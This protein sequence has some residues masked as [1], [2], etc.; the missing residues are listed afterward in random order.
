M[1]FVA[2][3]AKVIRTDLAFEH[4][5]DR[6]EEVGQGANHGQRGSV[7]RTEEAACRG[8]QQSVLDGLQGH[9]AFVQLGGQPAVGLAHAAG[10]ARSLAVGLENSPHVRWPSECFLHG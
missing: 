5:L 2:D 10:G 9:A 3:V 4:F 6:R 1:K 8:Q 7:G